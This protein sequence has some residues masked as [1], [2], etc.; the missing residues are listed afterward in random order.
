MSTGTA[1]GG[2]EVEAYSDYKLASALG[3]IRTVISWM[4]SYTIL[5]FCGGSSSAMANRSILLR[6]TILWIFWKSNRSNF[7]SKLYDREILIRKTLFLWNV[8]IIFVGI[9]IKNWQKLHFRNKLTSDSYDQRIL[10]R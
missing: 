8:S 5:L 4:N 2:G 7:R 6:C 10:F 9:A 1:K 3:K